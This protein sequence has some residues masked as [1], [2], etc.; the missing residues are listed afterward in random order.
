MRIL[1]ATC[2]FAIAGAA[3]AQPTAIDLGVLTGD[4]VVTG[5]LAAGEVNWYTFTIGT[6]PYIDI[7]TNDTPFDTELGV[8]TDIG[9]L[10]ASDDD[11]GFG[12]NST[13]SFGTGSGLLLGD[14]FNLGGNGIAEGEDGPLGP[15]TYYLAMGAF[16]TTFNGTN[17][18]ATSTSG[19]SGDYII[20]IYTIPAPGSLALLGLGGLAIRRRR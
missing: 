3:V 17:W 18:D 15:G 5:S 11:D 14:D 6:N 8:Y 7:T 19:A 16:N 13:L 1:A 4:T 2:A 20:S 12:L 10:V 9:N